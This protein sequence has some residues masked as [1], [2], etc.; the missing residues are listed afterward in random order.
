MALA[1]LTS[2]MST[3][4]SHPNPAG[5]TQVPWE[6]SQTAV[7]V[8]AWETGLPGPLHRWKTLR[9]EPVRSLF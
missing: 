2:R 6:Q 1:A 3:Y 7:Q 9:N 8:D 4:P 5:G